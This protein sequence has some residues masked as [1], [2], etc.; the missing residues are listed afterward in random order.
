[1]TEQTDKTM[2]RC[3]RTAPPDPQ[4]CHATTEHGDG[5]ERFSHECGP[6]CFTECGNPLPCE[7][8]PAPTGQTNAHDGQRCGCCGAVA[9]CY[10]GSYLACCAFCGDHCRA[11]GPVDPN[12]YHDVIEPDPA[13]PK[14]ERTDREVRDPLRCVL[15]PAT[16]AEAERSEE[17]VPIILYGTT[18]E[19]AVERLL[20]MLAEETC[21]GE[22]LEHSFGV[23]G[24]IDVVKRRLAAQPPAHGDEPHV[25]PQCGLQSN[26]RCIESAAQPPTAPSPDASVTLREVA[27]LRD[28]ALMTFGGGYKSDK[29]RKVFTHGMETAFR[30][31]GDA[32]AQKEVNALDAAPS[33]AQA[34]ERAFEEWYVRELRSGIPITHP[35]VWRS[36]LR[37]RDSQGGR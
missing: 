15:S 30:V 36:A 4:V 19:S 23:I 2:E 34:D 21:H 7:K 28:G 26:V 5:H 32:I 20:A 14:A 31:V 13:E 8:H 12:W 18:L 11:P 35:H 3:T 27:R 33:D 29:E 22:P 17:G 9:T 6:N 25:C 16:P 37:Y 10:T 24:A 1:M